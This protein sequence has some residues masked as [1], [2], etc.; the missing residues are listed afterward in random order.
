MATLC[1]TDLF[2]GEPAPQIFVLSQVN[3]S[4][5]KD[6]PITYHLD[7]GE[8]KQGAK[9]SLDH[10]DGA[11]KEELVVW[12]YYYEKKVPPMGYLKKDLSLPTAAASTMHGAAFALKD[13][14]YGWKHNDGETTTPHQ[15]ASCCHICSVSTI[16]WITELDIKPG[17]LGHH[18]TV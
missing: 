17:E 4:V 10:D 11:A 15:T 7:F 9:P 6:D 14:Q 5:S 1:L 16:K 3:P 13:V 8:I 12:Q 2:D 18:D